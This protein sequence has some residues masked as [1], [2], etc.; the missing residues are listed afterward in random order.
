MANKQIAFIETF[1]DYHSIRKFGPLKAKEL[2]YVDVA[3]SYVGLFYTGKKPS[4]KEIVTM[5]KRHRELRN[6]ISNEMLEAL[7]R[8]KSIFRDGDGEDYID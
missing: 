7:A 4:H 6:N 8:G 5:L 3:N 1:D 2:G